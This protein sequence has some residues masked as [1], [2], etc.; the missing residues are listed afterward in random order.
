M[1]KSVHRL[2]QAFATDQTEFNQHL[3][4]YSCGQ[5]TAGPASPLS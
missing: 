3:G 2:D 1:C 4:D 5:T